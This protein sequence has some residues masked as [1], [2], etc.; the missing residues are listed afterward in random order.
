VNER[1]LGY[2]QRHVLGI[3]R[4]AGRSVPTGYIVRTIDAPPK[5]AHMA[6]IALEKRGLVRHAR[7]GYWEAVAA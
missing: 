6:L 7:H 1:R 3:L 2:R 4:N 5:T